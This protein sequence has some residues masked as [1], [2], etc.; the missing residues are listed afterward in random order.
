M[1]QSFTDLPSLDKYLE[2]LDAAAKVSD[3][4]SRSLFHG[5]E[6][7]RGPTNARMDPYFIKAMDSYGERT[8]QY[9][10]IGHYHR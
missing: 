1:M 9:S 10:S 4:E 5:S 7:C 8:V 6:W 2:R 3:D